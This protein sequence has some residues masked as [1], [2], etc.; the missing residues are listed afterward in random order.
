M[1]GLNRTAAALGCFDSGPLD[2]E[3]HRHRLEGCY[4]PCPAPIPSPSGAPSGR[5]HCSEAQGKPRQFAQALNP[6]SLCGTL[7]LIQ[8]IPHSQYA[9]RALCQLFSHVV[10]HCYRNCSLFP[11]YSY[12]GR[13]D[14]LG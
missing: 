1:N 11:L 12:E 5:E 2:N 13:C 4:Q 6:A 8:H 9:R 10:H 7:S 3:M 14:A